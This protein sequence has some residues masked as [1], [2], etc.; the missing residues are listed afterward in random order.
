V[1]ASS[2]VFFFADFVPFPMSLLCSWNKFGC[3]VSDQLVRETAQAMVNTGL[4]KLGYEVSMH[5]YRETHMRNHTR[6]AAS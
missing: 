5:S 1:T 3:D 2:T 4:A 6:R